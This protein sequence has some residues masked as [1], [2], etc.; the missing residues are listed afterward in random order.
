MRRDED[1]QL[2][3]GRRFDVRRDIRRRRGRF[4][5]G[6][7]A[8]LAHRDCISARIVHVVETDDFLRLAVLEELEV[9]ASQ[10]LD[11]FA[12]PQGRTDLNFHQRRFRAEDDIVARV[13][14]LGLLS[15]LCQQVTAGRQDNS[16][17]TQSFQS[18]RLHQEKPPDG[19]T[20]NSETVLAQLWLTQRT[21]AQTHPANRD[22]HYRR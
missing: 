1:A 3:R 8:L 16:P 12:A 10:P 5:T 7:R 14:S 11:G 18:F 17:E 2:F 6:D 22:I 21:T 9:L 13:G 15:I 19:T 4:D 20:A